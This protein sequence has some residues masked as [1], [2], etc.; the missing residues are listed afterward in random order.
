MKIRQTMNFEERIPAAYEY[1][2]DDIDIVSATNKYGR[3]EDTVS[4]YDEGNLIAVASWP[5]TGGG[6]LYNVDIIETVDGGEPAS[7]GWCGE[8]HIANRQP[9]RMTYDEWT[10]SL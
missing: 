3:G 1:E 5:R 6:Y 2:V 10:K 8:S 4:L 9:R 7:N